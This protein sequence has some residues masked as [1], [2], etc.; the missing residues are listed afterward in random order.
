MPKKILACQTVLTGEPMPTTF[1][2]IK[3][4][5]TQRVRHDSSRKPAPIPAQQRQEKLEVR[6][7]K[8]QAI[9]EVVGEWFSY[10]VAKANDL[11]QRFNKKPRYFLDI[12][13]QG[14]AQMVNHHSKVNAHNA[15]K[16][17]KAQ[18]L[19]DGDFFFPLVMHEILT[20]Y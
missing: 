2:T 14:G 16:S 17:L 11:A 5:S 15:F 10:T 12:F 7:E 6:Q 4:A 13:F 20:F 8:Q 9:D 19:N 18:E 1:A 3:A